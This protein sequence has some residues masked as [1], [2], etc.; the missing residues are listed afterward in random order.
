MKRTIS[1]IL[2]L[3]M[4]T[5]V[6][7]VRAAAEEQ[8]ETQ[9]TVSREETTEQTVPQ[10]ETT[11]ETAAP[12]ER[13]WE[14]F[15]YTL[16]ADG[17]ACICGFDGTPE[18]KDEPFLLEVPESIQGAA[19]TEISE[20]A[21]AGN[22]TINALLLPKTLKTI[23]SGALEGCENLKVIAFRGEEPSFGESL[24]KDCDSLEEIFLLK[25][26]DFS[27]LTE[28][29][30]KDLGEEASRKAEYRSFENADALDA[31]FD[32]LAVVPESAP[33]DKTVETTQPRDAAPPDSITIDGTLASGTCGDNLTW[34][35]DSEGTLTISGSGK[36]DD[37]DTLPLWYDQREHIQ[38]VEIASGVTGIGA[39]A[40]AYCNQ[41]VSVSIPDGVTEIG[42]YAFDYCKSLK[43][44]E[45]PNSVT[46]IGGW[47]FYHCD[48][49]TDVTLPNQ[50]TSI[51]EAAFRSCGSLTSLEIPE[52]VTSIGKYAF[53]HGTSLAAI[54]I[55]DG[56]TDIG[57][58]AFYSCSSLTSATI[59]ASVTSVGESAFDN[60]DQLTD[61]YY[62]GTEEQWGQI[63]IGAYN[64]PLTNATIHYNSQ[65]EEAV[66]AVE[67]SFNGHKYALYDLSMTWTEAKKY[68]QKLGGHLVTITSAE[69][70]AF[71]ESILPDPCTKR[72]YWL[73][74]SYENGAWSWVTGEAFDYS[75]WDRNQ[76]DHQ[77]GENF[78]EI[79]NCSGD[80]GAYPATRYKWNDVTYD[81]ISGSNPV[82]GVDAIGFI[83]EYDSSDV[84]SDWRQAYYDY[85]VQ[86]RQESDTG[87]WDYV[88]YE[89]VYLDGDDIPE[90]YIT[91]ESWAAG[92]N[93]LSFHNGQV[94]HTIL[95]SGQLTYVEKENVFL[96]SYGHMG[97]FWDTIYTLTDGVPTEVVS[98]TATMAMDE[99]G[100]PVEGNTTYTWEGETVSEQEYQN[101]IN[102]YIDPD[103][104]RTTDGNDS[105]IY[106]YDG[107]LQYLSSGGQDES[108]SG[109]VI[110]SDYTNMSIS[111]GSTITL[112]AGILINGERSENVSG[113]TF[114]VENST[115]LR[116]TDTGVKDNCRYVK[117]KGLKA[118]ETSVI[119]TDSGTGYTSTLPITVYDNHSY[120]FALNGVP[121]QYIEKYP[122]NVY[123][124]NGLY[125]DSF[126][127]EVNDDQ[128][129]TVKFDVYNTNYSYGAVEVC[130]KDGKVKHAVLIKKMSSSNTSIKKA[131]WDNIGY[132][133]R[134]I[135]DG[136]LLSYRQE[137]GFS[138]KT[139]VTVRI[140]KNGYIKI[141]TDPSN[142]LIV[143]LVNS[144]DILMSMASIAGDIKDYD[145]NSEAFAEDLTVKL[146]TE[147]MYTQYLKDG[148]EFPKKLWK[149]VAKDTFATSESMGN[150]ADTIT[151][152]IDN[153]ALGSIIADT[154][155]DFGWSIGEKAFTY[156]SGPIG[157]ALKLMFF[158]G[159]V[160][161]VLIHYI[162]LSQ[163]AG[164]ETIYIHNQGGGLLASQQI[165]VESEKGFPEDTS[166]NVFTVSLAPEILEMLQIVNPKL[167]QE[168]TEGTTYTY[169]ISLLQNN[170][171]VQPD[172]E[173]TVYIPIPEDLKLLA[174]A[175]KT[176][177]YRV[178]ED[179]TLTCMEVEIKKGC[180]V[181]KTTHFSVYTIVGF[182]PGGV[183]HEHAFT[184]NVC[185]ICGIIGGTCGNA[186]TWFFDGEGTLFVTGTG[187]MEDFQR[188]ESPWYPYRDQITRVVLEGAVHIGENAFQGLGSLS[189]VSISKETDS[190]GASAF[191][192]CVNLRTIQFDGPAPDM[193]D[194]IFTGVTADA[195]Y[196]I[197]EKS[198]TEE[199]KRDYGGEIHWIGEYPEEEAPETYYLQLDQDYLALSV[200]DSVKLGVKADSEVLVDI[201]RWSAEG[202]DGESAEAVISVDDSGTVTARGSGTA[203]V[204]ASVSVDGVTYS[205]RC[206][207]DVVAADG[208]E[209]PIANQV[210]I[211][212][213]TLPVNR[214]TVELY[215]TQYTRLSA[216]LNFRQNAPQILSEGEKPYGFEN[217]GAAISAARFTD[218]AAEEYFTLRAA[219]D[220]TLEIIPS[221]AALAAEGQGKLLRSYTSSVEVT[222]QGQT[223]TTEPV[224]V[225]L[226]KTRPALKA[227][228]VSF[229]GFYP[230]QSQT[231]R[232]QGATV[233]GIQAAEMPGWLSL[234]GD[235]LT[236]QKPFAG[237][238][239]GKLT[240]LVTTKEWTGEF[241]V[242]LGVKLTT[243]APGLKLSATSLT[244]AQ[245]YEF[246]Q[247]IPLRLQCKDR[248]DTLEGLQ[249]SDIQAPE[250]FRAADFDTSD[251]SFR[252][253]PTQKMEPGKKILL[254]SFRNTGEQLPITI[255]VSVKPVTLTA[256]PTSV[257]LNSVVGD[258]AFVTVTPKPGDFVMN[259]L[260]TLLLTDSAGRDASSELTISYGAEGFRIS[261]N[262]RTLPGTVYKLSF[263][264]G[265]SKQTTVT[266]KTLAA[267]KSVPS[268]TLKT[269]GTVDLS[270]PDSGCTVTPVF[271][272]YYGG[273]CKLADWSVTASRGK[274]ELGDV[275]GDFT[276]GRVDGQFRI[277]GKTGAALD[278]KNTYTLTMTL[279]LGS[280]SSVTQR[281]KLPV[282]RTA[283]GLK[284]SK[285]SLSLNKTVGDRAEV[286][287]SCTTKGY[288]FTRPLVSLMDGT[289]KVS[290]EGC[291]DLS[292]GGGKLTVSTNEATQYGASYRLLLRATEQ[293]KVA[294]LTVKIPTREKSGVTA[295]LTARGGI[296][297]IRDG[298]A[299]TLRPVYKNCGEVARR[300][301]EIRIFCSADQY[302]QPVTGLFDIRRDDKG[303][304]VVTKAPGAELDRS[305]KYTAVLYASF[306]DVMVTSAPA[307]L[308][309]G[310]GS[311]KLSLTPVEGTLLTMD[312]NSRTEFSFAR[313]DSALN[314]VARVRIKDA[315]YRELF[316]VNDYGN[317]RYALGFLDGKVDNSLLFG[318]TSFS[319]PLEVFLEG[320]TTDKANTTVNLKLRL[321]TCRKT[322]KVSIYAGVSDVSGETLEMD[323]DGGCV[324]TVRSQPAG[325]LEQYT[326]VSS[327]EGVA[328]MD[329]ETG[330]VYPQGPGTAVLTCTAA[331][332]S[333]QRASV[334]VKVSE[335]VLTDLSINRT[336]CL[337]DTLDGGTLMLK[338]VY[339]SGIEK[340]VLSDYTCTP[341]VLDTAGTQSVTVS[342]GG[343]EKTFEVE[344][345]DFYELSAQV[346][347]ISGEGYNEDGR[348]SWVLYV[349]GRYTGNYTA[350]SSRNDLPISS[351]MPTDFAESWLDALN[352]QG[353]RWVYC[354]S[355]RGYGEYH[356]GCGFTLPDDPELAGRY[357]VSL[358]FGDVSKTATFTLVYEGDYTT[359]TGWSVSD[360]SWS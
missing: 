5:G 147:Q 130:D 6:M 60:C 162:D 24:A 272:N 61:V 279:T 33:S 55:P 20:G 256:K 170:K 354:C 164:A 173:V 249:V 87:N 82:V 104:S 97:S 205:D 242:T 13:T 35:L 195:Y 344:V 27:A 295:S 168:I 122:T 346:E 253:V 124:V 117:L 22:D 343:L 159:K 277:A 44:I 281:V 50:I 303:G 101:K 251:G 21:F 339:Q 288:A 155:F 250:G 77:S 260:E 137:S 254:V 108:E 341:A 284:L 10:Q 139:P 241:P 212:G 88:S 276:F 90:I 184:D 201:I 109:L 169:N 128:S 105:E 221:D 188:S 182:V 323:T 320:N 38:N 43:K 189:C 153:L 86:N 332:G 81:N 25:D 67:A 278:E 4:L 317:G 359:G 329:P 222:V 14:D 328:T 177:L 210:E 269:S 85:I 252:L 360:V 351:A 65:V 163:S 233:T 99:N 26:R 51:E 28:L 292:W 217:Q 181:F 293:G 333:K 73:G 327:D 287:V 17:A 136:D 37:F 206:R 229:N 52:G 263:S 302:T 283:V 92:C 326:W 98:G 2:V 8:P 32:A 123:N 357:Q 203:Y 64:D 331:D 178:E 118:G 246:S 75:N 194:T 325:A 23:G 286:A 308:K 138:K 175:G 300:E 78:L 239:S 191:D 95:G 166:L 310:M 247:G 223:F 103:H 270:F 213:V 179:G 355:D 142:S 129:A 133:I 186:L 119:F 321:V 1:L 116:V 46:S 36:M 83:C 145:V 311:A 307:V 313:S 19:V 315:K 47:C 160:E 197:L 342:Y 39:C 172:G 158:I 174:Y 297:V 59:P 309:L 156:F 135:R 199:A 96:H 214:V 259:Q 132:L 53:M 226:R 330:I 149:N 111:T 76:P 69:E 209:Q 282:K 230:D 348:V 273:L 16:L 115:I 289:G 301:E 45:I 131:V 265:G 356:G 322:T 235:Q 66:P 34:V 336:Y 353:G 187:A 152:N 54:T 227:E 236:L 358:S 146:V 193:A 240:L 93:L 121:I 299:I 232:I 80:G 91:Y 268:M 324:L 114:Q 290:A 171:E 63:S 30:E 9:Q 285:T 296:D 120:T 350:F 291:L 48:S 102:E 29:L 151:N 3:A 298:S 318:K 207:V 304:F 319:I 216:V 165:K 218:G 261:T 157:E 245:A 71:L 224:T 58:D 275:T 208:T 266:I 211:S 40:F 267:D 150:F 62:S 215:S 12:G 190:V 244:F 234:S 148:S 202:P 314:A 41:M 74:A 225:T 280:G 56:V 127:Y 94:I 305:R 220:R 248:K 110:F 262:A 237:S 306:G 161:N 255:N 68:C 167:Y 134:D 312:R 219:D 185:E 143:G 257:T 11:E 264:A 113:I 338:A 340:Q 57:A 100:Y 228:S 70:Q 18:K 144:A 196:N 352:G 49:L 238:A 349:T 200:G 337:G 347:N 112:S 154:A 31:A 334:T 7:P 42:E 79:F 316:Q 204:V 294:T 180:F 126:S 231:L 141:S 125:I 274:T 335:P 84:S 106:D 72:Q 192:G 271:R 183:S 176:K 198:W 140:P 243:K 89:L 107:I 15:R 258:R 345:L